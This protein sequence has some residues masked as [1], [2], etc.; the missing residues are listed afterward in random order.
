MLWS[1]SIPVKFR[2]TSKLPVQNLMLSPE[3]FDLLIDDFSTTDDNIDDARYR[4]GKAG[5]FESSHF[6]FCAAW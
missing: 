3:N 5:A 2:A 6:D 1:E 4:Q